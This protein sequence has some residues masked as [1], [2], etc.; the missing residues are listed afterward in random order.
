[1]IRVI[2]R[3][4]V[5]IRTDD[6]AKQI[7]GWLDEDRPHLVITMLGI[8]DEGNVLVYPRRRLP[9][10]V[11]GTLQDHRFPRPAVAFRLQY[12]RTVTGDDEEPRGDGHLD[13]ATRTELDRLEARRPETMTRFRYSEAIEIHRELLAVDPGTPVYHLILPEGVGGPPRSTEATR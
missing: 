5:G 10:V 7:E 9:R 8:N 12:R 6:V 3:G 1:M 2:N 11:D 4:V 13:E